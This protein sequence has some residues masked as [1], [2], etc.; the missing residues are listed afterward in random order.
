MPPH[1]Q[2]TDN[3]IMKT[4]QYNAPEAKVQKKG[5]RANIL[6]GSNVVSSGETSGKDF[7]I[8]DGNGAHERKTVDISTL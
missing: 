1:I 8:D 2:L 6:A 3:E 4:R 7:E 5:L